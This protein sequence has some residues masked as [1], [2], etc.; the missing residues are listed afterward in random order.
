MY[1][2]SKVM[3]AF[4]IK[5]DGNGQKDIFTGSTT[6]STIEVR[7]R[8]FSRIHHLFFAFFTVDLS[9]YDSIPRFLT[10]YHTI[11]SSFIPPKKVISRVLE[12]FATSIS[13]FI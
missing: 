11:Y 4:D 3:T 1:V 5:K 13:Y 7:H 9:F 8:N 12:H 10:T 2:R 6:T